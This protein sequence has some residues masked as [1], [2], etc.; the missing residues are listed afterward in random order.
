[1]KRLSG[2]ISEEEKAHLVSEAKRQS[3]KQVAVIRS[4]IQKDMKSKCNVKINR[5]YMKYHNL[6]R[7]NLELTI[8]SFRNLKHNW[9]SYGAAPISQNT[10]SKAIE[11]LSDLSDDEWSVV[12]VC[13]GS[14]QFEL[15]QDG[16]D[17][18]I[19]IIESKVIGDI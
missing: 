10:I 3:I 13:D 6:R 17:I 16:F 14:I 12:P 5:L 18:E 2:E 19:L 8:Q 9:D 1:M 7:D 4:L 15:S 11:Y